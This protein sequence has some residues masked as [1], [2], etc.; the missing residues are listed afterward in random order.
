MLRII[1]H[2][3]RTECQSFFNAYFTNPD[4]NV[5]FVGTLGFNSAC[6]HFP[7]LI[8][9][10]QNF[11][12]THFVFLDEVRPEVSNILGDIAASN[13]VRLSE[14]LCGQKV[15]FDEL[16][17]VADDTANVAGRNAALIFKNKLAPQYTD[18]IVDATTMSRGVCFPIVKYAFEHAIK[19]G[20]V[21]VHVV[22]S[23][24]QELP[25]AVESMSKD[26]A[27]YMHGFQ[28]DMDTDEVA[29]AIK[30]WLPQLSESNLASLKVIFN[31]LLAEEV[32]PIL[33]FPA[34]N[35]RRGDNLLRQFHEPVLNEWDTNLLDI[36]YAHESD[37]TDVFETIKRI[38]KGRSEALLPYTHR[39][40][41]SPTGRKIGSLG[42]LFAAI[43][44]GLPVMYT[45]TMGY[46]CDLLSI[47]D[48]IPSK[49]EKMWHNWLIG[50]TC[51]HK[52]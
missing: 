11:S 21:Q 47:P 34:R 51:S 22:I 43:D 19:T 16:I 45:E 33:P 40:I 41:L 39:I 38:E 50:N 30:L 14:L 29:N 23:E 3:T 5:L 49:P 46:R 37:P 10:C 1:S 20:S 36:I 35:P 44:L 2:Q 52:T 42:M 26:S 25:Y 28:S 32:A 18:V 8:S 15:D 24:E 7:E 17:V 31:K 6:L 4:R 9:S 48:Y 12:P 27:E 13:K